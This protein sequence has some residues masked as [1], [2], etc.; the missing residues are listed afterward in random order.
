MVGP[1]VSARTGIPGTRALL[2]PGSSAQVA[3]TRE[4]RVLGVWGPRGW[5]G[6][7]AGPGSPAPTEA[8]LYFSRLLRQ[9]ECAARQALGFWGA[10]G[11]RGRFQGGAPGRGPAEAAGRPRAQ[12]PSVRLSPGARRAR[13]CLRL[14]RACRRW[15]EAG[16]WAGVRGERSGRA[17][18]RG[19]AGR[20]VPAESGRPGPGRRTALGDWPLPPSAPAV[21]D[22][23]VGDDRDPSEMGL[24]TT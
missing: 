21:C 9:Q 10:C 23:E 18:G 7:S 24:L 4:P 20:F 11:L 16:C 15:P 14:A 12:R 13:R 22:R 2:G 3:Q 8:A 19:P 5:Q 1:R 17:G 6:R